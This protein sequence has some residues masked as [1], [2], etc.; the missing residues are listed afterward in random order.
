MKY[1][2][3]LILICTIGMAYAENKVAAK[4]DEK[5]DEKKERFISKNNIL[6][7][8][9]YKIIST[10]KTA[11]S[12]YIY[13]LDK[14]ISPKKIKDCPYSDS[15]LHKYVFVIHED[16]K[17][18]IVS[19]KLLSNLDYIS[20]INVESINHGFSISLVYGQSSTTE[21][22][23]QFDKKNKGIF[24]TKVVSQKIVPDGNDDHRTIKKLPL[25]KRYELSNVELSKFLY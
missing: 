20:D 21:T 10:L 17:P 15:T 22:I 18:L 19:G 3:Y 16:K 13:I 7:S 25:D 4:Y 1:F 23:M 14:N 8:D 11:N 12:Q 9:R 24:L 5:C 2:L 6:I